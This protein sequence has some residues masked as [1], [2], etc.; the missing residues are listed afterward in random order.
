MVGWLVAYSGDWRRAGSQG[1][2]YSAKWKDRDVVL[3]VL[4]NTYGSIPQVEKEIHQGLEH[5]NVTHYYGFTS[6]VEG[7]EECTAIIMERCDGSL[8]HFLK[9]GTLTNEQ[10]ERII[11]DVIYG[12]AYLVKKPILVVQVSWHS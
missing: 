7:A 2:V 6:M 5:E 4:K 8:A 9:R 1:W 12:L 3:K 11:V 10:K